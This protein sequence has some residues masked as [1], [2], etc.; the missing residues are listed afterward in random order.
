MFQSLT[1]H[2]MAPSLF[3]KES[4]L[5]VNHKYPIIL[6]TPDSL[7]NYGLSSLNNVQVVVTDEA[8]SLI[9]GG[10]DLVWEI[11]SFSRVSIVGFLL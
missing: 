3:H 11:L 10:G 6:A 7:F 5:F 4:K 8:D 9:T 1:D 2:T